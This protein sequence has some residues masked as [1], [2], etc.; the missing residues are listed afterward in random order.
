MVAP[1]QASALPGELPRERRLVVLVRRHP[2]RETDD[3]LMRR[4]LIHSGAWGGKQKP[5]NSSILLNSHKL[6]P[7]YPVDAAVQLGVTSFADGAETA[8]TDAVEQ[9]KSAE[10][11]RGHWC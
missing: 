4:S 11:A 2:G 1:A 5:G 6:M 3:E 8:D 9:L 10:L 7:S